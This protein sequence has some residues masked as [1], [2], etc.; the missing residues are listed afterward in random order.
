MTA[1]FPRLVQALQWR[2]SFNRDGQQFNQFQQNEQ[3]PLTI[4]Y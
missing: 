3:S 4:N 1:H 2:D